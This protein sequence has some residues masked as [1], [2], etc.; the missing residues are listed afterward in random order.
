MAAM[1]SDNLGP[2]MLISTWVLV[3]L[4]FV[5]L[6]LRL[7]SKFKIRRGLW[8]DDYV[9]VL[10]WVRLNQAS[11]QARYADANSVARFVFSCPS[12]W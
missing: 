5:F 2:Q 11:N 8:W 1:A 7:F 4:S 10:S 9:L 6:A 3:G 12:S